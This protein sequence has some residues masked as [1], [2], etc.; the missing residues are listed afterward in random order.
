MKQAL[1]SGSLLHSSRIHIARFAGFYERSKYK[2]IPTYTIILVPGSSATRQGKCADAH[3]SEHSVSTTISTS[4]K[5]RNRALSLP[6]LNTTCNPPHVEY[7]YSYHT[8]ILVYLTMFGASQVPYL[9]SIYLLYKCVHIT[10][11]DSFISYQLRTLL[12]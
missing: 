7:V 12:E 4:T 6:N 8:L 2:S 1:N 5:H 11:T 10:H 9:L 3:F